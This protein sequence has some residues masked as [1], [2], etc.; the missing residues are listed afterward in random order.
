MSEPFLGI[1][2]KKV[3]KQLITILDPSRRLW[4]Y[5]VIV[6]TKS[7]ATPTVPQVSPASLKNVNMI[8]K[9]QRKVEGG[10]KFLDHVSR[11]HSS[12]HSAE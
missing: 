11:R 6:S 8:C 4:N 3:L 7:S 1:V 2:R 9:L 5:L 10:I 12:S